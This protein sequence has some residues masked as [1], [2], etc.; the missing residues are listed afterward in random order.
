MC[1]QFCPDRTPQTQRRHLGGGGALPWEQ[2]TLGAAV[3]V[4]LGGSPPPEFCSGGGGC[5]HRSPPIPAG[6]HSRAMRSACKGPVPRRLTWRGVGRALAQHGHPGR[7]RPRTS[8]KQVGVTAWGG[9]GG[10]RGGG[11]TGAGGTHTPGAERPHYASA[12]T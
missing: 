2:S 4:R 8:S 10:A 1:S 7:A 12:Q 9:A 6:G 5:L 3:P 11:G